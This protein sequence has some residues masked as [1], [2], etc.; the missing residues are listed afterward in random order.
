LKAVAKATTKLPEIIKNVTPEDDDKKPGQLA[1]VMA[2][3]GTL[4]VPYFILNVSAFST[5]KWEEIC[6]K[7]KISKPSQG[8]GHFNIKTGAIGNMPGE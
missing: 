5:Q 1:T 6:N 7:Y 4:L 3:V 8:F 2:G